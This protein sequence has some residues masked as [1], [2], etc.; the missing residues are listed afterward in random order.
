MIG[1]PHVPPGIL[2]VHVTLH[3]KGNFADVIEDLSV[4]RLFR[5]IQTGLM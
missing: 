2:H 4:G 5:I 1:D 3:G